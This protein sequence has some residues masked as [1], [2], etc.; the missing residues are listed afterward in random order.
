MYPEPNREMWFPP[1]KDLF[2]H[3]VCVLRHTL[4]TGMFKPV[5]GSVCSERK[6]NQVVSGDFFA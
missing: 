6:F 1:I 5:L 4:D 3:F 2:R